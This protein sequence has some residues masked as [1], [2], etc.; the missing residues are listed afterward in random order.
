MIH[1]LEKE[2]ANFNYGAIIRLR[3]KMANED[4]RERTHLRQTH[5]YY[6]STRHPIQPVPPILTS[7]D[8]ESSACHPSPQQLAE[9]AAIILALNV[10]S[11]KKPKQS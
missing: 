6:H 3:K 4:M 11:G 8:Q 7:E 2:S 9:R 10:T 5:R 1:D